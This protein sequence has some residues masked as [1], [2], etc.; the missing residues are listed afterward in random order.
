VIRDIEKMS[1][2]ELLC[3]E[4]RC[5]GSQSGAGEVDHKQ[6][7]ILSEASEGKWGQRDCGALAVRA[8]KFQHI[9]FFVPKKEIKKENQGVAS[10]F[11]LGFFFRDIPCLLVHA[12]KEAAAGAPWL[13]D[14]RV[15]V[16]VCNGT[17]PANELQVWP[18][19]QCSGPLIATGVRLSRLRQPWEKVQRKHAA[20]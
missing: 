5:S 13:L 12:E 3:Q 1:L 10:S 19:P 15:G 2:P 20:R 8:H 6:S 9:F 18:K 11:D 14:G 4:N 17:H 7:E 16:V